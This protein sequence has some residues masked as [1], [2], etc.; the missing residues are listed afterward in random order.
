[1]SPAQQTSH[2]LKASAKSWA[3]W[4]AK[5]KAKDFA[6]S[7]IA[8]WLKTKKSGYCTAALDNLIGASQTVY[9]CILENMAQLKKATCDPSAA[10]KTIKSNVDTAVMIA[11]VLKTVSFPLQ[12][13]PFVGG[14]AK[15][16]YKVSNLFLPR[17]QK[18]QSQLYKLRTTPYGTAENANCCPFRPTKDATCGHR[19]GW[20]YKCGG[21][22]SGVMCYAQQACNTLIKAETKMNEWKAA[23]YDPIIERLAEATMMADHKLENGVLNGNSLLKKCGIPNCVDAEKFSK[24]IKNKVDS[25]FHNKICPIQIPRLSMPD[26]GIVKMV[27]GWLDKIKGVFGKVNLALNYNHCI[28]IPRVKFWTERKCTTVWLPCCSWGR[29]RRWSGFRCGTCANRVCAPIPRS[30]AW[31]ERVCFSAM[32]II[33]WLTG[34]VKTLFGVII[35]AIER[36]INA[37]LS[38]IINLINTLIDKFFAPLNK[39]FSLKWPNLPMMSIDLPTFPTPFLNLPSIPR[40]NCDFVKNMIRSAR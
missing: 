40:A 1:M 26:L 31:M 5:R 21:C 37:L 10:H 8:A 35:N 22:Q 27:L 16:L 14:V 19:P 12:Y 24:G 7:E 29:R 23:Y 9:G 17:A 36:A 33:R 32:H 18:I 2:R 39:L 30:R 4:Q 15:V 38:P 28:S 6:K 3:K 34:A 13:V 11:K 25:V 20:K